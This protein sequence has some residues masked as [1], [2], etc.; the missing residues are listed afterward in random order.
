MRCMYRIQWLNRGI[1]RRE[2]TTDD[3]DRQ[4]GKAD[5]N[6]SQSEVGGVGI[7][8]GHTNITEK[9][10]KYFKRNCG[11]GRLQVDGRG[12]EKD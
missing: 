1:L 12:E 5:A 8:E 7:R 2:V 11:G 10:G 3:R 6:A 4:I 9:G